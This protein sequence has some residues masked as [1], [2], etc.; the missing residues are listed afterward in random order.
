[1]GDPYLLKDI[2]LFGQKDCEL[3]RVINT[4]ILIIERNKQ[5]NSKK[6]VSQFSLKSFENNGSQ[7]NSMTE[8]CRA[9]FKY[10]NEKKICW[11]N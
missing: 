4:E 9:L 8:M 6:T 2:V 7:H 1:M 5:I 3:S 10:E 11:D